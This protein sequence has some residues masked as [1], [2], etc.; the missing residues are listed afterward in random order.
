MAE[1]VGMEIGFAAAASDYSVNSISVCH[2]QE[3]AC[4]L[5]I[6]GAIGRSA[7]W[8]LYAINHI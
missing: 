6:F 2:M 3:K 5:T 8:C 1:E 4:I 7:G